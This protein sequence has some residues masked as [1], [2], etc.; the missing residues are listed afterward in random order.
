M[1]CSHCAAPAAWPLLHALNLHAQLHTQLHTPA[2]SKNGA[3]IDATQFTAN[4]NALLGKQLVATLKNLT[5]VKNLNI[6]SVPVT[7]TK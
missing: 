3:T 1:C 7:A 4:L 6:Y 2:A 5:P